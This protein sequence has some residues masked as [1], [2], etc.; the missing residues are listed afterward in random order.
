[1]W[2]RPCSAAAALMGLL[3][4][5]GP[6]KSVGDAI[7][8]GG[9]FREYSKGWGSTHAAGARCAT[10]RAHG[11]NAVPAYGTARPLRFLPCLGILIITLQ[12]ITLQYGRI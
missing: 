2:L 10:A 6:A 7:K 1:M 11:T 4:A 3:L 12:H 5:L 8:I 9:M